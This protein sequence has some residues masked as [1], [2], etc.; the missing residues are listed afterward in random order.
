VRNPVKPMQAHS[1][2]RHLLDYV[3]VVYKRRWPAL[4]IFI[5]I[6][7]C[8]GLYVM[9][10][11]PVYEARVQLMI[12]SERPRVV[13]FK[14]TIEQDNDK[15]DYQQ[16]QH[17][18]LQ[19]RGLAT[20]VVDALS[21][22]DHPELS[23][24]AAPAGIRGIANRLVAWGGTLVDRLS[25]SSVAKAKKREGRT[26]DE[27]PDRARTIDEF[28]D[29]LTVAPVRNSRLVDVR[30]QSANPK[31]AA[32]VANGLADAYIKQNLEFKSK[33]SKDASEWLAQQLDEQRKRVEASQAALQRYREQH[34][35]VSPSER[36]SALQQKL[37]ELNVAIMR[38]HNDRVQKE[39][40]YKQLSAAAVDPAALQKV[41]VVASNPLVLSLR[42]QLA[43]LQRQEH[44]M[45]E[46][47][48]PR[49]PDLMKLRST[50]D[51]TEKRI[52]VEAQKV[53]ELARSEYLAARSEEAGLTA[54][55]E[56]QKRT[57]TVE[58]RKQIEYDALEREAA[59]DRQ[60]FESLLQRAK[61]TGVSSELM[62]S[63]IRVV[64]AADVPRSPISPNKVRDLTGAA[65]VGLLCA[66]L[67]ALFLEYL[68]KAIKTP[69]EVKSQLGLP[70]LGLVPMT[71]YDH[72]KAA[73]PILNNGVPNL[74]KEAFRA[75]RTS[76]LFASSDQPTNTLLITSTGPHEGKTMV[77]SNLAIALAQ[78]GRRVL[79][80]DADLR[81][82]SIHKTFSVAQGPG[83]SALAERGRLL[84]EVAVMLEEVTVMTGIPE[85]SVIPAGEPPDNP[86][87][88]L[89]SPWFAEFV[90]SASTAYDW[91]IIDSP[92][93]MAVTDAVL[94]ANV[95]GAVVFVVRAEL[96]NGAI[97]LNALEKLHAAHARFAGVVLNCVDLE[98]NPYYYADHYRH[99]YQSYY[100]NP[101]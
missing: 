26:V 84:E 94:I 68:D 72:A 12:E 3:R 51:A 36:D 24:R 31:L 33:T 92:P 79:L 56:T 19:S 90:K 48:G 4:A 22:W 97:A 45:R 23:G 37:S 96:T 2:Q 44:Q 101:S 70:C 98:H 43:D 6:V 93:V 75:V 67:A 17:K 77:A 91:V 80:I 5:A 8:T 60:I 28:L 40:V 54:N 49:H 74:F 15:A 29:R 81:R 65:G 55:V 39:F 46:S 62:S 35:A 61:E 87:E 42:T 9:A 16:T 63:N 34:D 59:S 41:P 50:I 14:D 95:V 69:D 21:L 76:I 11:E 47:F 88:I 86:A 100:T 52:E 30:F 10:E 1:G 25:T 27:S 64:D 99:E 73:S 7:V 13:I 18:I 53:V 57:A 58:R 82:A 85:L 32:S 89:S 83:L 20:R 78:T 38:A 71:G 66:I